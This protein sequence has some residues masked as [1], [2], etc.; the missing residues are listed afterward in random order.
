MRLS[1]AA[2]FG[3]HDGMDRMAPASVPVDAPGLRCRLAGPGQPKAARPHAGRRPGSNPTLPVS[4][5]P[6]GTPL[7]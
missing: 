6:A 2:G 1:A 7:A 4:R 3:G 5:Q